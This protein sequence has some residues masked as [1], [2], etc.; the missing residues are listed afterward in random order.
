MNKKKG[1]YKILVIGGLGAIGTPL[2]NE[3]KSRGHE[4]WIADRYMSHKQNY[5]KCDIQEFHQVERMLENNN[6]DFVYHLAAEFGR[7]NGEENYESVWKTNV[8][9]TKHIIRMQERLKFKMIFTSSSEIYGDYR[10][11]MSEDIPFKYPL[12]QLNDYAISKWVN[13]Q[14]ILNSIDRFGTETVIVRLFNNYGPYEPYSPF[15]S[16]ISQFIYCAM[17]DIP[18]ICYYNHHRTSSYVMDTTRTMA[19]IIENFKPGEIYNI[20]GGEYHSMKQL[21]DKVLELLG[22]DDK[23]IIYEPIEKFNT[24]NKKA[25]TTKAEKDLGHKHTVTLVEGLKKTIEWQ[26]KEYIDRNE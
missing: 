4:V 18:I 16:V 25:D 17:H 20:A 12:R 22:K 3:L 21:S 2:V 10:G 11:I 1:K 24:L 15:R 23:H 13:E 19:N 6:F 26:K 8:I 14:Q 9:G 5:I 7:I